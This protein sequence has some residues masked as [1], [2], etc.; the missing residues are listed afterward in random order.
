MVGEVDVHRGGDATSGVGR[1]K[2]TGARAAAGRRYADADASG[3][4]DARRGDRRVGACLEVTECRGSDGLGTAPEGRRQ[5]ILRRLP[6]VARAAVLLAL[7]ALLAWA[8]TARAQSESELWS[9]NLT[10]GVWSSDRFGYY[11]Q[12]GSLSEDDIYLDG[13]H[14]RVQR[15]SWDPA[16][17]RLWISPD[18]RDVFEDAPM[19]L[20]VG[21]RSYDFDDATFSNPPFQPNY[22][23]IEWSIGS[24]IVRPT[25]TDGDTVRVRL[26][27]RGANAPWHR[28]GPPPE[29]APTQ[30][31]LL[32]G[33]LTVGVA[34]VRRYEMRGYTTTEPEVDGTL[35]RLT[36]NDFGYGNR[37]YRVT[38]LFRFR[39]DHRPIGGV[40]HQ[41]LLL[42]FDQ[43]MPAYAHK[44]NDRGSGSDSRALRLELGGNVYD[45]A[46]G[47]P[48]WSCRGGGTNCRFRKIRWG[49]A[50]SLSDG[51]R[52]NVR[53]IA[54]ETGFSGTPSA[55]TGETRLLSAR[56]VAGGWAE[57]RTRYLGFVSRLSLGS[58]TDTDFT[59]GDNRFQVQGIY[60]TRSARHRHGRL[61]VYMIPNRQGGGLLD[62]SG[63][64][65]YMG[66]RR[67]AYA[68]GDPLA[69]CGHYVALTKRVG[70]DGLGN[71]IFEEVETCVQFNVLH[72]W[73][74]TSDNPIPTL[75]VGSSTRVLMVRTEASG[76]EQEPED[77]GSDP[78]T[79]NFTDV[80]PGHDG[81]TAFPV[82]LEFSEEPAAFSD[83][84]LAGDGQG[85][86]SVLEVENAVVRSAVRKVAGENRRWTITLEPT[87]VDE[88]SVAL[89]PA[90]TC[91]AAGAIC[92]SGGQPL[93]YGVIT[94]I[95][96]PPGISVVDAD[97]VEGA[98]ATLD[99]VVTMRPPAAKQVTVDYA[100]S[101]GTATAGEDYT[102]ASGT[103]TFAA[104]DV[105]KTVSVAVLDDAT[106][107]EGT[108]T[109]TLTL[110]GVSG[111]RAYLVDATATGTIDD[112]DPVSRSGDGNDGDKED[113]PSA[114]SVADAAAGEGGTASFKVT[115]DPAAA[116]SVTVDYA[117][118]DGTA[119]AGEDY[120]A[121]SGT[122]TLAAG[123][124]AK[125]VDVAVLDDEVAEEEET[126]ALTLSNA[127]GARLDDASATGTITDDD[128]AANGPVPVS[129]EGIPAGHNGTRFPVGIA[130]GEDIEGL[131]YA[132][133]RD[134]LV[135]AT[136]A[137]V[138]RASRT[139]P[140]SNRRWRLE[141]APVYAGT[142]VVLTVAA[143]ELPGGRA[144]EAGAPATVTGQSLSVANASAAEG[145]TASFAV[146]LDR[147]ALRTVTVD[148]ATSD[149]TATAGSDYAAASGTLTFAPGRSTAAVAVA[150]LDDAAAEFEETFSL[151]LSN[152]SGAGLADAVA[153][154]TVTDDDAP[155]AR[156]HA[157]PA[158][159]DGT[160]AF[161]AKV[162]L[163]EE[164]ADIG[165]AWV[166][167]T[168]VGAEN[169]RVDRASRA[170]PPSNVD[171]NLEVS[172]LSSSAVVL[173]LA[174]GLRLPDTRP[175]AV[176]GSVT[177]PGPAASQGHVNGGTLTLVWPSARDGFGTPSGSDWSVRVNGAPRA[178][179]SAEVA[180]RAAVL[181]LSSPVAA[182]D[183]VEAGYVGSAMHPLADAAGRLRSAPWDGL[184]VENVTGKVSAVPVEP[185]VAVRPSHALASAPD[186]AV[187]IDASGLGLAELPPL[188]RF[189]ALERLDLSD[190]A[191]ED[192]A[193]LAALGTLREL[194]LSGNRIADLA[195][196]AALGGLERLDLAGNRVTDLAPLAGV[197][198]LRVLV[199]DGNRVA[200][201]WPLSHL[202]GLEQ[203][204]LADSAV[205]DITALQDLGRLR[206][207]DLGGGRVADLSPLGDV[208]SLEWLALPDGPADAATA[209]GRLTGLRWL[210]PGT[211]QRGGEG[212]IPSE[213]R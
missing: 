133:V 192:I 35:G 101:D 85:S 179:A 71:A 56:L 4:A 170:A 180:G 166:R 96:G 30:T 29:P 156:L 165:Y 81:A 132:W 20:Y 74:G 177:V 41:G 68:D 88:V 19:R 36:D 58:L 151:T 175:L 69:L 13:D 144:I 55:A 203:L 146:T 106:G 135:A 72:R 198:G 206:R 122:L 67:Y 187:R 3:G 66:N 205:T 184:P 195:S 78:F 134:T 125:T 202:G 90:A 5:R 119:T 25:E 95:G 18:D 189:A 162:S 105:E 77:E 57:P 158:E 160:N 121:A 16:L 181:V 9:S 32:T 48:Q 116:T 83:T 207:L 33:T 76:Q 183:A 201:L 182:G 171:W 43:D 213:E 52:L 137:V 59:I 91:D 6:A 212:V 155:K 1:G 209:L 75:P 123:E 142:D 39:D 23:A 193:P 103:L 196:L 200:D 130:I 131:G 157:A 112:D 21:S 47:V 138:E 126:F 93:A 199:L 44:G 24:G 173:S 51:Q 118:A 190:N 49:T 140:P 97:A 15:I 79:A 102:A 92:T 26:V 172:P 14:Y 108:E 152:P 73:V 211:P 12:R 194:D 28:Q 185:G 176:G 45:L 60:L 54:R 141:V 2:P 128:D 210:W 84:V 87:G 38:S 50:P 64:A 63:F 136:G 129:F 80:P 31:S 65:L 143:A 167:D 98:G 11:R 27:W 178:V 22:L 149:G 46:S 40:V 70:T 191:L 197:A 34:T 186:G 89:F 148:Y 208:G 117:T 114:L 82:G 127:S 104:G 94:L 154:G 139:A 169:G 145:G 188:G 147:G 8:G 150:A 153:T 159:H 17:V 100:T 110:S 99:F 163:S 86:G 62:A 113:D 115:L 204:G 164:I 107:N 37:G 42:A 7:G 10:V 174:Q 109:L 120:S 161:D 61:Y 111:D 168:L 124:T 53:L